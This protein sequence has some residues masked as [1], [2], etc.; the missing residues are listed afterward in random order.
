VKRSAKKKPARL[1]AQWFPKPVRWATEI[2]YADALSPEEAEWLAQFNDEYHGGFYAKA[3]QPLHTREEDRRESYTRKNKAN[4]DLLSVLGDSSALRE[5]DTRV[6]SYS[7]PHR[8][9]PRLEEPTREV[10]PGYVDVAVAGQNDTSPPPAYLD[11]PEYKA[12]LT[13][14]RAALTQDDK[15]STDTESRKYQTARAKLERVRRG[16]K[17]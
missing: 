7:S 15:R 17:K 6:V 8:V 2:D 16:Y 3:R 4:Q 1:G 5:L 11:S 10:W 12:A 13:A 14:Y 9:P